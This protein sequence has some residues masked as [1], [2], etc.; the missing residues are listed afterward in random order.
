VSGTLG[1]GSIFQQTE[2]L[3]TVH[4]LVSAGWQATCTGRGWS[5]R[6]TTCFS[7]D[8]F[9]THCL[10]LAERRLLLDGAGSSLT[11]SR[12]GFSLTAS[13]V[14]FS[15]TASLAQALAFVPRLGDGLTIS[16]VAVGNSRR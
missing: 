5:E 15:L 4:G 1:L 6:G 12:V 13:R 7:V 8:F 9:T 11:E 3:Q 14:G 2:C 16:S 10:S